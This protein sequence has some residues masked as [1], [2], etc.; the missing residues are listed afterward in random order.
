M[1]DVFFFVAGHVSKCRKRLI[2]ELAGKRA[3]VGTAD[4]NTID[5]MFVDKRSTRLGK[6]LVICFEGN[7]G[8]YEDGIMA[9]PISAGYST[10]GWNH[11]GFGWSTVSHQT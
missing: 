10:L 6:T 8:Y 2:V 7:A 9:T 4:G 5:T 3:K 1:I 11:P